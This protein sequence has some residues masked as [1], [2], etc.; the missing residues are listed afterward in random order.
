MTTLPF[1]GRFATAAA[2]SARDSGRQQANG[3]QK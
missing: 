2:V 1:G 3:D